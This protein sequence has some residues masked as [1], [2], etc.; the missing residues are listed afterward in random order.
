MNGRKR[1]QEILCANFGVFGPIDFPYV[2][3]GRVD[4]LHL[5]AEPETQIFAI[6]HAHRNKW[7][8]VADIG[9]NLGLHSILLSRCGFNVRCYEPD[10]E[11][12]DHLVANLNANDC[13]NV[14][15]Y[16]AAVHTEDGEM[17]F[18]RVHNNMTGSH[19]EGYK[20]S[21]GP[22]SNLIV[23][24]V[25]CRPIWSWADFVKIDSEGNEADLLVTTTQHDM[26]HL[27]FVVEVRNEANA[28]QIYR[29]FCELEVP[30]WAAKNDWERVKVWGNVPKANREGPLYI[31]HKGPWE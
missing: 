13:G 30:M 10:F 9:A 31:G 20:N 27:S 24:I 2:S 11:H 16:M 18:V 7:K 17:N 3:M 25:D 22:R 12:F 15:P 21:Y 23:P 29:H 14:D 28:T 26:K 6:Y 8:N 4:S 5:F 19:L 1:A